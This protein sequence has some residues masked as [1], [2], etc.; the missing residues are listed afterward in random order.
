MGIRSKLA[1]FK[2]QLSEQM[3]NQAAAITEPQK[4]ICLTFQ[5]KEYAQKFFETNQI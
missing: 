5:K 2:A 3:P 1:G 4:G